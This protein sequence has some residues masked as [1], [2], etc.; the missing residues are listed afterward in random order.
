MN[1]ALESPDQPDVVALIAELDAYQDTLYPPECRY[2]L[3]LSALKRS[4]VR[5]AVARDAQGQAVGCGALVLSDAFGEI[6][7][8]YVRPQHRGAGI[9]RGIIGLLEWQAHE[10]ACFLLAL[11]TGP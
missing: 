5:F 3:D 11:E 4:N 2:A 1:I 8:M 10:A 9:A 7:R 6:K